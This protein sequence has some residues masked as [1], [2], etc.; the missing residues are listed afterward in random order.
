MKLDDLFSHWKVVRRGLVESIDMFTDEELAYRPY[1]DSRSVGEIMLHIANAEEGWFGYVL[2]KQGDAWPGHA[3]LD[4][5]PTRKAIKSLL[6]QV[7]KGTTAY[8]AGL[9]IS[10]LDN[11]VALPWGGE[12]SIGYVIW[13][14][15]E[16]E[17]HHRGE[18]SLILG[19]LGRA[20]LEV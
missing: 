9:N 6:E 4:Q 18:L 1:Q 16:H 17:I 19:Q 10:A 11:V 7:H 8:L 13:H 2:K 5:Y 14:V 15:I 12:V 3:S 20:G